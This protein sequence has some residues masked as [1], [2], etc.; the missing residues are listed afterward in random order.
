MSD[1]FVVEWYAT[2]AGR[3]PALEFVDELPTKDRAAIFADIQA[4]ALYGPK[5]PVSMK[6]I[7]GHR[8]LYEIRTLGF[9]TFYVLSARRMVVLHVS[10]KEKAERGIQVA[11]RRMREVLK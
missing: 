7:K 2:V 9:R 10:K 4:V 11:S 5:A 1:E 3:S 8:P 6:P